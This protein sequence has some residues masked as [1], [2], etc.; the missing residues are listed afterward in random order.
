[1]KID[2]GVTIGSREADPKFLCSSGMKKCPPKFLCRIS[3]V[4]LQLYDMNGNI[5]LKQ[6]NSSD[7]VIHIWIIA[8]NTK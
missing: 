5:W 4:T 7:L 3:F 6:D 2:Q 1:M 8:A